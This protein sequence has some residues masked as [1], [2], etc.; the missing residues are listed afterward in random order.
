[1]PSF[2]WLAA[3]AVPVVSDALVTGA[4]TAT[5]MPLMTPTSPN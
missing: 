4:A 3:L 1:M 5:P 2:R